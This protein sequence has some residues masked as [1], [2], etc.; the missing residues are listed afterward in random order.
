MKNKKLKKILSITLSFIIVVVSVLFVGCENRD[1]ASSVQHETEETSNKSKKPVVT[2]TAQV[3][4]DVLIV[5]GMCSKKTDYILVSGEGA[6]DTKIFPYA[7]EDINYFIGQVK[8]NKATTLNVVASENGKTESEPATSSVVVNS[9][10]RNYMYGGEYTPVIGKNSQMHFYSALLSYS[11]PASNVSKSI[12]QTAKNNISQV[13]SAA[14]SVG[15]ET[16]FLIIPSS[17]D[18]YPESVPEEFAKA[19]GG[20][21]YDVFGRI[22]TS[23]GA[24]VIYPLDTMKKHSDDGDGYQIYQHTDS[25]WSTYGAYWGTYDLFNYISEKF[26]KAKPRTTDEMQFYLTEMYGGDALFNLPGELGFETSWRTGVASKTNIKELTTLYSL[27]MPT[28]TLSPIYNN[29]VGLYLTEY[30]SAA[31]TEINPN[32]E[33]LPTAVIMRDSF[34]KVA[35]DMVNDRFKKVY[36]GEFNNYNLPIDKISSGK[37][38]YVIYLYSERNLLKLMLNNSGASILNIR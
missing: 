28:D 31:A 35:Y 9:L 4:D 18:I 23:L 5:G 11:I 8:C 15:A 25:H 17:A 34:S 27:K 32:G 6:E 20:N 36:W 7:G 2:L 30:N 22:A 26:P 3:A 14:N 12:E 29:N 24:K 33:G 13:V 10:G 19:N 38:D 37:P 21:L 16:I 1:N